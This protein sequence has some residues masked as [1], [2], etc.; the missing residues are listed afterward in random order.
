MSSCFNRCGNRARRARSLSIV[1]GCCALGMALFA[2]TPLGPLS[3]AVHAQQSRTV[4]DG[5]Y[6]DAQARRGQTIYKERCSTC[7]GDALEG[8]V[9]PALT[10]NDFLGVWGQQTL[11]DLV[12]KIQVTMPADSP[13]QLTRPQAADVV[14]YVL[15][16]GKFPSGQAELGSDEALLKQIALV[17]PQTPSS[18]PPTTAGQ[19]PAFPPFGNPCTPSDARISVRAGSLNGFAKTFGFSAV[20]SHTSVSPLRV[21]RST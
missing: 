9:G 5:V 10:G 1:S 12:N 13:G 18:R 15:Q 21:K 16:I 2:W 4:K 14:A 17:V 11:S 8:L 6:T 19:V 3:L 7:H 20:T